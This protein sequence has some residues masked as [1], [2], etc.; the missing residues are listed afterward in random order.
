MNDKK[1][2]GRGERKGEREKRETSKVIVAQ[3]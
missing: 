2:R 1:W 3:V